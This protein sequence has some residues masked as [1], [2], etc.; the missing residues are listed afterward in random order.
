MSSPSQKSTALKCV[1]F[2]NVIR[3][4]ERLCKPADEFG[5][6]K[7]DYL[8]F[9]VLAE[10]AVLFEELLVFDLLSDRSTPILTGPLGAALNKA[11]SVKLCNWEGEENILVEAL[12]LE[13]KHP[14][15]FSAIFEQTDGIFMIAGNAIC[16]RWA[17][18]KYT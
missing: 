17:I 13:G 16:P 4:A 3:R 2:G 15:P 14:G 10:A 6:T 7:E 9:A 1:V 18:E 11:L 12:T 8:L 5:P